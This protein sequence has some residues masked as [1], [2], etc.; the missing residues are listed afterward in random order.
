MYLELITP[1]K[2]VFEGEVSSAALPGTMGSFEVL[3]HHAPIISSLANGTV[4]LK[5][6]EGNKTFQIE[7][8]VVEV[9]ANKL[10]VLAEKV[11]E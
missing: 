7:G 4:R 6:T 2:K 5:T 10:V 11:I 8:G 9:L 1:D 3:N